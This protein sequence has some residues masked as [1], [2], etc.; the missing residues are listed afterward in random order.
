MI[1]A[2]T[3]GDKLLP[4]A[5]WAETCDAGVTCGSGSGKLED[6]GCVAYNVANLVAQTV[7]EA[8]HYG[9]REVL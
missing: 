3:P 2:T 9:W 1:G 8:Q 6:A 4:Q 5:A 7:S